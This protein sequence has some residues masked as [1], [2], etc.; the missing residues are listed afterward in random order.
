MSLPPFGQPHP[1][2]PDPT[3][4]PEPE[5]PA[6]TSALPPYEPKFGPRP[7]ETGQQPR[8]DQRYDQRYD[9]QYRQQ[10]AQPQ[11][12][13]DDAPGYGQQSADPY[14]W[15]R[16]DP[17]AQQYGGQQY[18]DPTAQQQYGGQYAD[19]YGQQYPDSQAQQYGGQQYAD[20][21]G[22]QYPDSQA[23]QYGGQQYADPYG[24]QYADPYGRQH[25]DPQA[26]QFGGGHYAG[27]TAQQYGGQQYAD[28]YG[29]QYA[30]PYARPYADPQD[31]QQYGRSQ[32]RYDRAQDDGADPFPAAG[33]PFAPLAEYPP[34]GRGDRADRGDR[35]GRTNGFA[36][37]GLVFGLIGG[38]LFSVVF[39]VIGLRQIRR[40]GGKGRGLAV[41]GLVLSGLWAV[42]IVAFVVLGL[43]SSV[44]R[45]PDGQVTGAG[46]VALG[47]L[48]VGDCVQTWSES[49]SVSSVRVTPC[50]TPHAAQVVA[51]D[52]LPAPKSA[53][54]PGDASLDKTASASCTRSVEAL[55]PAKLPAKGMSVA[56]FRPL[57]DSWKQ[58]DR[59]VTCLVVADTPMTA[60]VLS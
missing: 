3:R 48:R 52:T 10:Y 22:Q 27:P 13:R 37:A 14:G 28:P 40:D 9:E 11:A 50:T 20:P 18:A 15:Q 54:Y 51:A 34:S 24:Q 33:R 16:A 46:D 4:L 2:E 6:T 26:Q 47:D 25:P 36:I 21:Y 12:Q 5:A 59:T 17:Q 19:P 53:K 58:G 38:L 43:L 32:A 60:T 45:G 30:D 31:D 57:A 55:D 8:Y 56:Y 49:D 41:T 23:Q 39:S 35:G 44:D 42:G 29:Q 7:Y 1:P